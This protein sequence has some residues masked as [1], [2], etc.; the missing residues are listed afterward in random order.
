MHRSDEPPAVLRPSDGIR[1]NLDAESIRRDFADNLFYNQGALPITATPNDYYKALAYTVR[2]RLL[3]RWISTIE[4][5]YQKD[6]KVVAY[7]S[8]EFLIGPQLGSNIL[9][10]DIWDQVRAAVD[11]SGL[12]LNELLAEEQE[13]GLGNGG[14]GR[15]AACYLDSLA[16][17]EIPAVGYGIRY[18]YGIFEQQ[19]HDGWQAEVTD[20]WLEL[21]N[22][23]EIQRPDTSYQ[24]GFGGRTERWTD[25]EGRPRMRWIPDRMVRGIAHDMPILGYRVNTCNLLRLWKAE[26][27][28]LFDLQ[29]FNVGDYYG[30][31]DAKVASE[32]ITKVLYPPDGSIQGKQLRLEQEYFFV[33]ASLQ[34]MIAVHLMQGRSLDTFH[35]HFAV[36][37]NDTHPAIGV[38]ELQR[39]LVDVHGL[40]WPAAWKVVQQTF[41]YTNHTLLPEALET[42]SLPLFGNLLPRHLEILF[43]I[44]KPFLEEVRTRF[45]NDPD[46]LARMS[47]IDE[48][49]E[50]SVR[51][52]H[53][54]CVGSHAVNGVARLHTE[55]LKTQV[56]RDFAE[57]WPDRFL[58]R[59][60]GVS[61]R[62]FLLLS[63]PDLS[64]LIASR[65]GAAWIRDLDRLRELEPHAE[66]PEF[67]EE[68]RKVKRASKERLVRILF[69][70]TG[71]VTRPDAMLDVQVKRMH[72]YKRQH[73]NVLH[74]ITLYNRLRRDPDDRAVPRTI[75]IAGKAAPGYAMARLIIKLVHGVAEVIHRDATIGDRLKLVFFPNF[76]VKNAQAIYPAAE[77]SEQISL[78][79]K[80]AS[81]T[82]NMKLALNGALTIG[83]LDG[84]NIEIRDAVGHENFFLFGLDARQ[85][86]DLKQ[87]GTPPEEFAAR[88]PELREALD[89]I[90]AGA[91]SQGDKEL[92]RPL[93][94]S[95]LH[96]DEFLV[97]ADY[98]SYVDCQAKVEELWR[99]P[100]EWTRKAILNVA[101]MGY[102]SSDRAVREY[103]EDI[104]QARPVP[105]EIGL[106]AATDV[107]AVRAR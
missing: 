90:G 107:R 84:A 101:R 14:L 25:G 51:M 19:I 20:K 8:A 31:V 65:I 54:A 53:L 99:D 62:R 23:W 44:N 78:A 37:L 21:G 98:R 72:E 57:L 83:T 85:V 63:N 64:R 87:K 18:E 36:Q 82:G 95:L 69:E 29:A 40:E 6:V 105:I 75:L 24:V 4:S 28:E 7:L 45:P 79:G 9:H 86:A 5:L 100:E 35:R 11:A 81:G 61:P 106:E 38:A 10:L 89:M 3:R 27:H 33:S 59:T 46:R 12:D 47:L 104:W 41:A 97:L 30:A 42:W 71:V 52:A 1:A 88:D 17:L 74:A 68:W 60:N 66:D 43:D 34:D 76:N 32:N 55:L 80:E 22:P 2:E 73:L 39:L 96:R 70:R 93:L 13:P 91:F 16:T 102:F 15:L 58:N 26:A 50:R 56:L 94:D 48:S 67:R 77:L 49:G 103:C 92:F